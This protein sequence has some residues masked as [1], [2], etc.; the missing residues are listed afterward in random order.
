MT[1]TVVGAGNMGRALTRRFAVAGELVLLADEDGAKASSVAAEVNAE[2]AGA[3]AVTTV[4]DAIGRSDVVAF[5]TWYPVTRELAGRYA[6]QL[7]G[8][9]VIDIS[10]P[11]NETFDGLT[12]DPG[13]SAAEQIAAAAPAARLVKAFNTT[14]AP[15]LH[16][17]RIA[18]Q[19]LDILLAGDDEDAKSAVAALAQRA[20]LTVV[21]AG[22]LTNART[23][24]RMTLLLVELQSRYGL[25]FNAAFRF[26]PGRAA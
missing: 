16:E 4:E 2:A 13:T 10:N 9:V 24:E 8:K 21:D 11:F 12:T 23:L 7:A 18:D 26:T 1:V 22:A 19:S 5:A 6:A 20:D 14:F 3:V 25:D 15:V 17:G